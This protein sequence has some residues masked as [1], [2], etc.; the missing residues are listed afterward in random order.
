LACC[1]INALGKV[2]LKGGPPAGGRRDFL[3]FGEFLRVCMPDFLAQSQVRQWP[4]T[5]RGRRGGDEWLYE[6]FRCG[7]VHQFYPTA[8]VAWGRSP[9]RKSY[10]L[11]R[12][13][14][15]VLNIDEFVRGFERGLSEFRRQVQ[16]DPDLAA[17][18]SDYIQAE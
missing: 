2:L 17:R 12:K 1:Y 15:V 7:F 13:S 16:A 10:W 14:G 8:K 3:R 18:F 6:V 5:P 11:E 4:L 9:S